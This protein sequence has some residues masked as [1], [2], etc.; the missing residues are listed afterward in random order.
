MKREYL[1]R[2][3]LLLGVGLLVAVLVALVIGVASVQILAVKALWP[4]DPNTGMVVENVTQR[5]PLLSSIYERHLELLMPTFA[6]ASMCAAAILAG[7]WRT[8]RNAQLIVAVLPVIVPV[9]L[10]LGAAQLARRWSQD[11]LVA[12]H[13]RVSQATLKS[14]ANCVGDLEPCSRLLAFDTVFPLAAKVIVIATLLLLGPALVVVWRSGSETRLAKGWSRA[15]IACF[16]L[17]AIALAWTQAHRDDRAQV[18]A[19]CAK[20]DEP[21][22]I[23]WPNTSSLDV[24]GVKADPCLSPTASASENG[25]DIDAAFRISARGEL[26]EFWYEEPEQPATE[27][28][29]LF[30]DDHRWERDRSISLYV[31]ESTPVPVLAEFLDSAREAGVRSALLLGSGTISGEFAT[32]GP[33]RLRVLCGLGMV[34]LDGQADRTIHEFGSVAELAAA[35]AVEGGVGLETRPPGRSDGQLRH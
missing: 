27:P 34:R 22:N 21:Q 20:R 7:L 18:M 35:A 26:V 9:L 31:D 24:H 28:G 29:E 30:D 32:L 16:L 1:A 23:Q 17:G 11:T 14:L 8:T 15:A 10:A 6:L 19:A 2:G 5:Y 25:I 13:Q 3:A 33:W 4:V 12:I